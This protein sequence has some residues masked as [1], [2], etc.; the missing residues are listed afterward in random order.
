MGLIMIYKNDL[1]E[2]TMHGGS[3]GEVR[4]RAAEGLGPVIREY[5]SAIYAGYDGQ[6]TLSSRATARSI[7][8]ALEVT[9]A[10]AAA[11]VRNALQIFEKGGTLY[12]KNEELDRRIV[13]NQVQV[14]EVTRVLRGQISSFAVQFVCDNPYFEDGLDTAVPL[15]KRTKLLS[16]PFALPSMFGEIIIG[17]SFEVKGCIPSEPVITLYY[18]AEISGV[19]SISITNKTTGKTL[20]LDYAP[21]KDDTVI[22][23][24]KNRKITSSASGNL[25]NKLAAESFLG[26]FVLAKGVNV[27]SVVV[28]DVT[29]GF[30]IDCKYNNLYSE[31]VIV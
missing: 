7:T 9:G 13:C 11:C 29:S 18:P 23:D 15:Y 16:T 20:Q 6:E 14:P 3:E 28:G 8:V 30:A 4:I 19:E 17:G 2:V 27:I 10:N 5:S 25:I 22:I 21:Q 12:I 24:V 31:A 26:D 1:G